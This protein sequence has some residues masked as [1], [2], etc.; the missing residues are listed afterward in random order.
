MEN[1]ELPRHQERKRYAKRGEPSQKMVSLRIDLDNL[2]WLNQQ[3][4]KGRY[5]NRLISADRDKHGGK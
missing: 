4:N 1:Q 2:E 5:I 3:P